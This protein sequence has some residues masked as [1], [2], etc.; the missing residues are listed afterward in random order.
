MATW[1]G[2]LKEARLFW[3]VA[4][5]ANDPAH[6]NQAVSNAILAAIAANDAVCLFF[7]DER[8]SG[9]SHVEAARLLRKACKGTQWE[10]E[11]AQRSRQLADILQQKSAS[12]YQGR[13]LSRDAAG[14]VM[15]Q[16]HR[17]LQ[18]A[19]RVLAPSSTGDR[20]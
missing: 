12:Q 6:A 4:E 17:F 2:F 18:W 10:E 7:I 16:A 11:S 20:S 9:Q 14:R 5:L 1:Q 8:P 19:E 15:R 3:D 13:P